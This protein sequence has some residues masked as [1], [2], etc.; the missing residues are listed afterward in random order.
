MDEFGEYTIMD[1]NNIYYNSEYVTAQMNDYNRRFLYFDR[2]ARS[3][4]KGIQQHDNGVD[5]KDIDIESYI[6]E[7]IFGGSITDEDFEKLLEKLLKDY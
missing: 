2:K 5:I 7:D 1:G 6:K 3:L 4:I